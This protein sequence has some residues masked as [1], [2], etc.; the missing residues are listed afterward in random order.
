MYTLNL[1]C[2]YRSHGIIIV[3]GVCVTRIMLLSLLVP[4]IVL[5][6]QRSRIRHCCLK[7]TGL[8]GQKY[9]SKH[10]GNCVIRRYSNNV[11]E[12]VALEL[13]WDTRCHNVVDLVSDTF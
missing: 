6:L 8:E 5:V 1:Y 2:T 3:V 12:V 11:A 10:A 4:W 9:I 13:F 7:L